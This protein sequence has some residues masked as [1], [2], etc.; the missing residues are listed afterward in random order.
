MKLDLNEED[1][2]IVKNSLNYVSCL[3]K[4]DILNDYKQYCDGECNTCDKPYTVDMWLSDKSI[5]E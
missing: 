4:H 2:K 3:Y 1:I 5:S